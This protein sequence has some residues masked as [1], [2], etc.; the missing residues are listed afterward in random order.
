MSTKETATEATPVTPGE[1]NGDETI[2]NSTSLLVERYDKYK[3]MVAAMIRFAEGYKGIADQNVKMN[4]ELST[5]TLGKDLPTFDASPESTAAVSGSVQSDT[6]GFQENVDLNVFLYSFRKSIGQIHD[7]SLKLADDITKDVIPPMRALYTEI[8]DRQREFV[9]SS[10]RFAKETLQY[11]Q[12]SKA[13]LAKFHA[14]LET[15]A[16]KTDAS[17]LD[18]HNDPYLK[19]REV[20]ND[21]VVQVQK[22]NSY[23][24]FLE[25]SERSLKVF[26]AEIMVILQR[27]FDSLQKYITEYYGNKTGALQGTNAVF[28]AIPADKEWHNFESKNSKMLVSSHSKDEP[29]EDLAKAMKNVT[30]SSLAKPVYTKHHND[31][32]RSYEDVKYDGQHDP[33]TEPILEGTLTKKE[34]S[35]TKTYGSYYYAI[36]QSKYLL[37]FVPSAVDTAAPSLALYLPEC[38]IKSEKEDAKFKFI[39]KGKDL[40]SRLQ[41]RKKGYSFKASSDDE[42]QTW[43]NV[44]AEVSGQMKAEA[45]AA[46]TDDEESFRSAARESD[47]N[48]ETETAATTEPTETEPT[49][50][51]P[52][53][54]SD[55]KPI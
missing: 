51:E 44:L 20:V 29:D 34:G 45:E 37:E 39:I 15:F 10:N 48:A 49:A 22:E 2:P 47:K 32:K 12:K 40:S 38:T 35:L 31:L 46:V 33:S 28:Q 11:R 7:S 55:T 43:Y 36:T 4:A 30:I 17:R 8:D 6:K 50:T 41:M 19:K 9:S 42:F 18:Y 16:A 1:G 5:Q 25:D 54:S 21:T 13:D 24:D 27:S 52:T 14:S 26:E 3:R 53:T 23:V